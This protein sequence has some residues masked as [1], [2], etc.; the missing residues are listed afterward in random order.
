MI[1]AALVIAL[2]GAVAIW[3]PARHATK[4]DPLKALRA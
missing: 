4:I 2:V 1:G 3:I